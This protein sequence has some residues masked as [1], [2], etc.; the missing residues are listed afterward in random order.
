MVATEQVGP[1]CV[2]V[3]EDPAI[4]AALQ[5]LVPVS[6][7]FLTEVRYICV[8]G[9][10]HINAM[11]SEKK[12]MIDVD[13]HLVW[14]GTIALCNEDMQPLI[15]L[16]VKVLQLHLKAIVPASDVDGLGDLVLKLNLK[17]NAD[18]I[19]DFGEDAVVYDLSAHLLLKFQDS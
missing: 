14:H 4:L 6:I 7:S 15:T 1:L 3:P 11:I 8:D 18:L 16:D 9:M 2:A 19:I 10:V 12:G 5:E 17:L 13:L